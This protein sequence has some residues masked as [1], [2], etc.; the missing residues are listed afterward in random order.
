[1]FLQSKIKNAQLK[2]LI[3]IA[4]LIALLST[5]SAFAAGQND[6]AQVRAATAKF[7]RIEAA[8]AAGYDLVPGLDHCFENPGV[9]GMGIHYINIDLLD[10][11]VDPLQPEAMVYVPG[12]DG[13]WHLGAVEYIVPADVWDAEYPENTPMVLGQHMHLNEALGV[14]IKH[15]WIWRHNPAGMFED[16]NP[17]VTCP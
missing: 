13:K 15:A 5:I 7:H 17:N 11:V 1:M 12:P 10:L 16:W 9:G 4:T 6:L 14:Y 2:I 8:Q 3:V